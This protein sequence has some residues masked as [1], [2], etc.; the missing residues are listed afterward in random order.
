MSLWHLC[1]TFVCYRGRVP[2]LV[3]NCNGS[4]YSSICQGF[5]HSTGVEKD[6]RRDWDDSDCSDAG[7]DRETCGRS[8][9]DRR[10][11]SLMRVCIGKVKV[12]ISIMRWPEV[13]RGRVLE[14]LDSWGRILWGLS[15][16]FSQPSSK[17]KRGT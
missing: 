3:V 15:D 16:R 2:M 1:N 9:E 11:K 5:C 13:W 7:R 14:L 12:L 10:T 6:G 17:G 8:T 4:F